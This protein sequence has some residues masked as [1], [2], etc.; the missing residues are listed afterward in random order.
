MSFDPATGLS[1]VAAGAAGFISFLSPCVLPLVPGY[2]SAVTG[3]SPTELDT[4][5]VRRIIGPSLIFVASFSTVFVLLG[6]SATRIGSALSANRLLLEKIAAVFVV[7]MGVLFVA[8]LFVDRLNRDFHLS[9]LAKRTS[10]GGPVVAG[11]AFALAWTPCVGPTLSAILT[12]AAVSHSALRGGVLLAFYAAGLAAPFLLS[13][14]AFR[15]ATVT[16][17]LVKRHYRTIV[18]CGGLIL[19]AMG[20]LM[21]TNELFWLNIQAQ[22]VLGHL[23]LNFF[24]DV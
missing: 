4:A 17:R 15:K 14:V 2:L 18:A 7:A 3:V 5:S 22:Q 8:A 1:L 20:V 23:G 24:A 13:A 11:A 10:K 16:F 6:V 12:T 19:V 9:A 21:W